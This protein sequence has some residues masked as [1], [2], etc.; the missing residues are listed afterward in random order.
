MLDCAM[1]PGASL[2]RG[3]SLLPVLLSLCVVQQSDAAENLGTLGT[4]PRWNVLEHYQQTITREEFTN[5]LQNVYGTHG[6]PPDT[7]SVAEN[8]ARILKTRDLQ[9]FFTL[10]FAPEQQSK[11]HVPRRWRPATKLGNAPETKPLLGLRVALDPGH[12][13]G[14]WARM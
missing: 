6:I 14:E 4:H 5:L 8:S 12:L 3:S 13:G 9:A 11:E 10:R 2:C 7:I 1:P